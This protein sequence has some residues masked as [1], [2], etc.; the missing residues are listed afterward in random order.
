[1]Q[2]LFNEKVS[3]RQEQADEEESEQLLKK[4][5]KGSTGIH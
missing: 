4:R 5:G 2:K 1:M 3:S